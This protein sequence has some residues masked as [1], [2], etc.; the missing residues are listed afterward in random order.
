MVLESCNSSSRYENSHPVVA[1]ANTSTLM[2]PIIKMT[3]V[4]ILSVLVTLTINTVYIA[5]AQ[6]P[7]IS[8]PA[9]VKGQ[10]AY[11]AMVYQSSAKE[12]ITVAKCESNFDPKS[13]GD[14]GLAQNVFQFHKDT[15]LWYAHLYH[16]KFGGTPLEYTSTTDQI[17]LASWMFTL[18]KSTKEN[19]TCW[20][21]N[22]NV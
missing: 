6:A 20:S 22:F 21:R 10:I 19:W 14:H 4:T 5:R 13:T 11:Y 18:G 17:K 2:K 1:R 12:L 16:Q 3:V 9:D 7:V 15:F 8:I